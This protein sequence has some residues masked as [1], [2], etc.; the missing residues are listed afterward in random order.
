MCMG[1]A[2]GAMT[3][4]AGASGSRMWL[5]ARFPALAGPRARKVLRRSL[6]GAGVLAAGILGPS[7]H[8]PSPSTAAAA[9]GPSAAAVRT[10]AVTPTPGSRS[11]R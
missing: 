5:E 8:G 1:C 10:V 11:T 2:A 6:M 3:A 4:V 9:T 7:A